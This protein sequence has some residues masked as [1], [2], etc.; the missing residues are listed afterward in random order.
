MRD[1]GDPLLREEGSTDKSDKA[2]LARQE[3]DWERGHQSQGTACLRDRGSPGPLGG[4]LWVLCRFCVLPT[5]ARAAAPSSLASCQGSWGPWA[6]PKGWQQMWGHQHSH[7]RPRPP[8]DARPRAEDRNGHGSGGPLEGSPGHRAAGLLWVRLGLAV[9][10]PAP[11]SGPGSCS[12]GTGPGA[13]PP[14]QQGLACSRPISGFKV[15]ADLLDCSLGTPPGPSPRLRVPASGS[16]TFRPFNKS[17]GL[18]RL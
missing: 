3:R 12:C 4:R 15:K 17:L 7:R 14:T 1:L 6:P 8:G 2:R 10:P 16:G 11:R 5:A 9:T 13:P 18:P